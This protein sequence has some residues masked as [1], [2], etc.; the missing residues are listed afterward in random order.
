M[1][2]LAGLLFS[3]RAYPQLLRVICISFSL[4]CDI[5]R[6]FCL[7]HL[8]KQLLSAPLTPLLLPC[9]NIDAFILS[10]LAD[11]NALSYA[12][13]DRFLTFLCD[14]VSSLDPGVL[15]GT[16]EQ[17]QTLSYGN[18]VEARIRT[19]LMLPAPVFIAYASHFRCA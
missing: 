9:W 7:I 8:L 11:G 14:A 10:L 5:T 15:L 17:I 13:C 19:S 2:A 18:A 1:H 12:V 6:H 3:C 16:L 4:P